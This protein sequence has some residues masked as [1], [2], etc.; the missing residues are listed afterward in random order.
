MARMAQKLIRVAFNPHDF[1]HLLDLVGEGEDVVIYKL[2]TRWLEYQQEEANASP[3]A[4]TAPKPTKRA[5]R[6][7]KKAAKEAS[8]A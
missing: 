8:V 2:R 1:R 7:S 3:S 6:A 5:P 4:A